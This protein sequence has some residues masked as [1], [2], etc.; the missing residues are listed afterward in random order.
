[1]Y[2]GSTIKKSQMVKVISKL[3]NVTIPNI[4]IK[5]RYLERYNCE[6]RIYFA[7]NQIDEDSKV[8]GIIETRDGPVTVRPDKKKIVTSEKP[9]MYCAECHEIER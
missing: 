2:V 8:F 3:E 4:I 7:L 9:I 6:E 5:E 1:M